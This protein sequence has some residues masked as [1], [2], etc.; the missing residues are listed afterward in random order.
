MSFTVT[1]PGIVRDLAEHTYHADPIPAGSLSSTDAKHILKSPMH[2]RHYTDFGMAPRTT[3]DHGH[4]IHKLILGEGMELAVM[5]FDSWRTKEAREHRDQSREANKVPILEHELTPLMDIAN[6]VL[7]DPSVGP[8]FTGEGESELS[9]FYQH[10]EHG[11]WMRGRVDRMVKDSDRTI[12][13]DVKTTRDADPNEFGRT[14]AKF[15]YDLQRA[16]YKHMWEALTGDTV[17]FLHVLIGLEEPTTLSVVELDEDFDWTGQELMNRA[18]ARYAECAK[19]N[20]W[21]GYPT[22]P[23]T[24]TPPNYHL[25]ALEDLEEME[26]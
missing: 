17:C 10:P 11:V 16:W 5:P 4:V 3:F 26:L 25:H 15:G 8:Y 14:A 1:K 6:T 7:D 12:L 13:I 2:Y 19:T 23:T 22:T 18:L 24:V 20:T 9:M 21:P